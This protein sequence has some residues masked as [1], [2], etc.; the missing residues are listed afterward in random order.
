MKKRGQFYLI[1][2]V[3]IIAVIFAFVAI[4]NY[5]KPKNF[6]QIED[7]KKELEIE[8]SEVLDYVLQN[9]G[10]TALDQFT[11]NFSK[12][13]GNEINITYITDASES[14]D[15]YYYDSSLVK[16]DISGSCS[17]AEGNVEISLNGYVYEFEMTEGINFYFIISQTIGGENHVVTN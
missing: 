6:V 12:Y 5:Y 11:Q 14:L 8:S 15:C 9:S 17:E 2:A 13:A 4:S 1:A 7:L 3:I 10:S 16:Q